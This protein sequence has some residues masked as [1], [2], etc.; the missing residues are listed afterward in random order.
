MGRH[1]VIKK[2]GRFPDKIYEE[3]QMRSKH[4]KCSECKKGHTSELVKIMTHFRI[5]VIRNS[6]IDE[7]EKP[8]EQSIP[9]CGNDVGPYKT[10]ILYEGTY[11]INGVEMGFY[12]PTNRLYFLDGELQFVTDGFISILTEEQVT[13]RI[14]K[15]N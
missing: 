13:S 9:Y 11:Y 1:E 14:E 15:L 12:Y 8:I 3:K 6:A 5:I 2:L 10:H 7:V 4:W